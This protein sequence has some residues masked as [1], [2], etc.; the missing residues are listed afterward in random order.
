VTLNTRSLVDVL[1]EDQ[2]SLVLHGH[3]HLHTVQQ[4]SYLPANR[5]V[6][7]PPLH[8][9]GCGR[10]EIDLQGNVISID[11]YRG[12]ALVV[13]F[14]GAHHQA[15]DRPTGTPLPLTSASRVSAREM[16]LYKEV[17][18]WLWDAPLPSGRSKAGMLPRVEHRVKAFQDLMQSRWHDSGYV[19]ICTGTVNGEEV[20]FPADATALDQPKQ[21]Y[22][23]LLLKDPYTILLNNHKPIR[24]SDYGYWD[25]LLLPAFKSVREIMENVRRDLIR[26]REQLLTNS[27]QRLAERDAAQKAIE[28]ILT[29]LSE[30]DWEQRQSELRYIDRETFTRFSPTDATPRIYEYTLVSFDPFCY[31]QGPFLDLFQGIRSLQ[32]H[33]LKNRDF[34]NF[35]PGYCWFPLKSWRDCDSILARNEDVMRWVESVLM[36][37]QRTE[38]G[39]P[40]W[41]TYRGATHRPKLV[42]EVEKRLPFDT[43]QTEA[44][45]AFPPSLTHGLQTMRFEKGPFARLGEAPY[46]GCRIE[47]VRVARREVRRR[48]QIWLNDLS[49]RGLGILRPTQRYIL[50]GGLERAE[51]LRL[52]VKEFLTAHQPGQAPTIGPLDCEGYFVLRLP[53]GARIAHLPPIIETI[54]ETEWE[55][56]EGIQEFLVCDGNHRIVRHCWMDGLEMRAVLIRAPQKPYYAYPFSANEWWLTAENVLT[57]PPADPYAKYAPRKCEEEPGRHSY[58][59]Y[60]R[61]F[62]GQTAFR[63]VGGQGGRPG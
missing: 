21:Y 41:L 51:Y 14:S 55:N 38:G 63:N 49:G 1:Q 5:P 52:V 6:P 13:F 47:Q 62:G 43:G 8:I 39:I 12:H 28:D 33:E 36:R 7:V 4:V 32:P 24:E 31:A 15:T 22:L 17:G 37:V 42:V 53:G 30:E 3:M 23:L 19:Q 35:E 50:Q 16:R 10:Y 40:S 61:D 29:A 27:A 54:P 45:E 58:R 44:Y 11:L 60:F 25:T 57:I 9:V 18:A 46:V 59:A 34:R 48:Q 2:V 26:T 56:S 20:P